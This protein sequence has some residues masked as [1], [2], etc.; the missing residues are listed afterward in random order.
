MFCTHKKNF[1]LKHLKF[2][3][4]YIEKFKPSLPGVM[5][6]FEVEGDLPPEEYGFAL[7]KKL[8]IAR[9]NHDALFLVIGKILKEIRDK[10]IFKVLDY[11]SFN[12]FLG[13]DELGFSREKAYMCIKIYEYY[14]EYL[15]LHP[16]TVSKINISRLSMMVHILRGIEDKTEVVHK[17]EEL[18]SL[19]QAD[20]VGEIRKKTVY[21]EKPVVYFSE[22]LDKWVVKY[23]TD[24]TA[25]Q[26]LG[27]Y[28]EPTE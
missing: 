20:F 28:K 9:R 21:P 14:I 11:P 6:D 27:P 2:N 25:L 26:D 3:M 10:D 7:Y 15:E 24:K 8:L 4:D 19:G 13:S 23:Y 5:K 22:E 1:L 16:D 17:I 18:N 12:Q